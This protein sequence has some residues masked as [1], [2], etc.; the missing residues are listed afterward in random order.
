MAG[1]QTELVQWLVGWLVIVT[2]PTLTTVTAGFQ[3]TDGMDL[4]LSLKSRRVLDIFAVVNGISK[5]SQTI[6]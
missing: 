4:S 5:L 1:W 2:T 3:G 6:M